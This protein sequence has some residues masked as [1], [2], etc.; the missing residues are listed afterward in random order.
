MSE[1]NKYQ[2]FF[3]KKFYF[4]VLI[5]TGTFFIFFYSP[6]ILHP[7]KFI[8]NDSGDAI[9]NYFCYEWHIYHDN[10]VNE[11]SGSNYPFGEHHAYTDGNPLLS[12]LIRAFPF[13]KSYS[14]PIFH[15]SIFISF[16][17]CS[18]LLIKI[19]DFFKVPLLLSIIASVG[20]TILCPQNLRIGGHMTLS[21]SFAIPLIIYLLL[22]LSVVNSRQK[23]NLIISFIL[24]LYFFIHPYLGM[25]CCS[26]TFFYWLFRLLLDKSSFKY[27]LTFLISQSVI[28]VVFYLLF[29]KLTDNHS[30]RSNTPYG[31]LYFVS[32]IETVFISTMPPFRH[33]L[34]QIYKIRGQNWE[35]IAYIGI[36]SLIALLFSFVLVLAKRKKI[37][38]FIKQNPPYSHL[39]ALII[40]S[41][42]LLIF[43]MGIPFI[44]DME[45]LLDYFPAVR[46]FRAPGRFAWGF[47]FVATIFSTI[48]ISKHL[49][50]FKVNLIRK[51]ICALLLLLFT[52]EG[53]PFHQSTSKASFVPNCF[54]KNYI[55]WELLT[56]INKIKSQN[57]QAIIP[58][59][60]YH[61][62]SDFYY[63]EGTQKIK[64][65]SF[66]VSFHSG[67]S[68][69]ASL[70]PRTSIPESKQVLQMLS[71]ELFEKEIKKVINPDK[72]F[73]LLVSKEELNDDEKELSLKGEL[74]LETKNYFLR[75]ISA[76]EL[77]SSGQQGKLKFFKKNIN[78]LV[79]KGNFYATDSSYFY[80][81]NYDSVSDGV[82]HAITNEKKIIW[83]IPS[84]TLVRDCEYEV[85]FLY[86]YK[87][88]FE[89]FNILKISRNDRDSSIIV[90]SRNICSMPNTDG[91]TTLA[92]LSF[93]ATNPENEYVVYLLSSD[94]VA[95]N[96]Y[97]LDNFLIRKKSNN[98][99]WLDYNR[100]SKD[101]SIYLNNFKLK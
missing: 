95:K 44:W 17:L 69:V 41:L 14:V 8:L 94:K 82:L 60:F 65:A 96:N 25:I 77:L 22:K 31:F 66:I 71:H 84:K 51:T 76:H 37:K 42:V 63:V 7:S 74:L 61:I 39:T 46:Q 50:K 35:G 28:P 26:L 49:F 5:L 55:E 72:D 98:L 16:L 70:T 9:K 6:I 67:N 78:Q 52:I 30:E 27:N 45:W 4:F 12:N 99:Y 97:S 85:S 23:Y 90:N 79:K 57:I 62:G 58:L 18:L 15:F 29:L 36:T 88:G 40:S 92:R 24:L 73:I 13:L 53:I 91:K 101:T 59:P 83:S 80:F 20:I 43:S 100:L 64:R 19:F 87:N 2:Q 81:Q 93:I 89:L 75:K 3:Q 1:K 38:E 32:K 54:N 68:L 33:M 11:Y 34:S 86:N 21:Y 48:V 47:F 56:I 10:S